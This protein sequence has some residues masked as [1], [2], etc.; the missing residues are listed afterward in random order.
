ME[1]KWK[2]EPDSEDF[3]HAGF[4]CVLRRAPVMR[5]W[6]GYVLIKDQNHPFWGRHPAELEFIPVHGKVT[7]ADFNPTNEADNS[8]WWVGFHCG[9]PFDLIVWDW[10]LE[11]KKYP[12]LFKDHVYRDLEFAR[13]QAMILADWA[14][15]AME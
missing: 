5:Y 7:Y 15:K 2:E 14:K 11:G 8:S 3:I 12:R 9:H 6:T 1:E 13:E 4:R 10:E